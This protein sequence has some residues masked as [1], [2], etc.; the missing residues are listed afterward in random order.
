MSDDVT[1]GVRGH[2]GALSVSRTA[3]ALSGICKV[4]TEDAEVKPIL[5]WRKGNIAARKCKV[6]VFFVTAAIT[7]GY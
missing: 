3:L 6:M 7:N 1:H 5:K 2:G 4:T